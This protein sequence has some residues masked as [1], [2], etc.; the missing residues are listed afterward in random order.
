MDALPPGVSLQPN[1]RRCGLKRVTTQLLERVSS[2]TSLD[3]SDNDIDHLPWELLALTKLTK[4]DLKGNNRLRTVSEINEQAGV[5][6]VFRYLRDLY[7]D[8]PTWSY[9]LKIV[10]A[11]P[12]MAGKSS[13]LNG[14][15]AGE[16]RLTTADGRTVGLDI[17]MLQL[18]DHRRRTHNGLKLRFSC[19]DAGGHDEYADVHNLFFSLDALYMLLCDLSTPRP[20]DADKASQIEDI[21]SKLVQWATSIQAYAPGSVVQM[22]GSHADE[23]V[24]RSGFSREQTAQDTCDY[25]LERVK[26]VLEEQHEEQRRELDALRPTLPRGLSL[27]HI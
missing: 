10:L 27:I 9:S 6:G 5:P 4:L 3:I 8:E 13:L 17:K 2:A 12:S 16:A 1:F 19:Y 24:A 23:V 21:V 7:R 15:V 11:G 25:Y 20:D 26:Q 18:D 22:V 14:L